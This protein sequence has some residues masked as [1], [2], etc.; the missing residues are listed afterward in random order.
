MHGNLWEWCNDWYSDKYYAESP[1]VDPQ[2]PAIGLPSMRVLRG[3]SFYHP[4]AECRSASR[5]QGVPAEAHHYYGGVGFRVV[6]VLSSR[7]P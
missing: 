7:T 4:P 3:G 1:K 2:G 6:L 5:F